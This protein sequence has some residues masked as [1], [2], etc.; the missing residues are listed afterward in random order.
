MIT[1]ADL[2]VPLEPI[3]ISVPNN[4]SL[5]R[6]VISV[7][8]D[9]REVGPGCIFVALKGTEND[10]HDFIDQAVEQGCI[11]IMVDRPG[12]IDRLDETMEVIVVQVSDS[13]A[14][15]AEM[16]EAFYSY[17]A[18]QLT[19]IGLTGTN[20]KTTC[21]WI[22]EA[23]LLQ[24]GYY[25]G[26]IGTVNYRYHDRSGLHVLLDA[27]LT[28]PDP[29][30]LQGTLSTMVEK[31]VTH[32]ILEVSSHALSQKRIGNMS[33]DVALFTNLTQDHLDYHMSMEEYFATKRLLFTD[34]LK[35]AGGAVIVTDKTESGESWGDRLVSELSSGRIIRCGTTGDC[36]VTAS[37]ISLQLD[38]FSS[39]L[40][41]QEG[42]FRVRSGLTG[43]FNVLN[44]LASVAIGRELGL[45]F[46]GMCSCLESFTKVPGRLEHIVLAGKKH[47]AGGADVFVDYAHTPDALKNVLKTLRLL[48]R[49]RLICVFGCGGDRDRGKRSAMGR[50]A[51][52]LADVVIISSDNPRRE[53]PDS[54][55]NDIIPGVLEAGLTRFSLEKLLLHSPDQNGFACIPDRRQAIINCCS[56]S[57]QGDTLL[58]AGKGHEDYQILGTRKFFFDDRVE[59]LNGMLQWNQRHLLSATG[60]RHLAGRQQAVF[61]QVVT[62]S[63]EISAG[64]VFVALRGEHFDGHDYLLAAAKRGAAAVIVER[65]DCELADS[66]LVILVD[67]TLEALGNL[68]RYRRKLLGSAVKFVG[69]TGSSGKTTV[70]EM[71]AAIFEEQY[72]GE[73]MGAEPVLKTKGNYNNLIGMP[74][75]LL[76]ANAGNKV[77]ILEMGMNSFGEIEKLTSIADPDIGCITNVQAA[78]IEGLGSIEGVARAKGELFEGMREESVRIIN[79]DDPRIRNLAKKIGGK[80]VGFAMTAAGRRQNPRVRATRIAN[81]GEK[82]MRFTLHLD[83]WKERITVPAPGQHNVSN[84]AAAAAIALAAGAEPKSIIRGLE[85]YQAVDKRLVIST[86]PGGLQMVN[87]TYNANPASM[88]AALKTVASFGDDCRRVAALGDMFELGTDAVRA[89][90]HV[91]TLVK[92]YGYDFLAVTGEKGELIAQGAREA[93]MSEQHIFSFENP[94]AIANWVFHMAGSGTLGQGD[95]LVVKGSRGMRME[96]LVDELQRCF[97]LQ[98]GT[99]A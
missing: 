60:G 22:L 72:R 92:L 68:A 65:A 97:E 56:L 79:F 32:V 47:G 23:M 85:Q 21:S 38:G 35:A 13:H 76:P 70:K 81:L 16:A 52:Q 40:H 64:D 41:V 91:G 59:A 19:C 78:H 88:E 80:Q 30:L 5:D 94:Q 37:D 54:I 46:A 77:G 57:A 49:K 96:R 18:T 66:V 9:S 11:A 31:G 45:N 71:T 63:R 67:D 27:P 75:S 73:R 55:I 90:I 86:L 7:T 24:Q 95:W 34:H 87:D 53:E 84:C 2:L 36:D 99:T 58:I 4:V 26:V 17:P 12:Y 29:M 69:I 83:N 1:I 14:A 93:G 74:L 6:K 98:T 50:I 82:G 48:A 3:G 44:A 33:F 61:N 42:S 39:K 8:S 43:R 10:G 89:H 25:P 20:G 15:L 51:A 28:T 62:D